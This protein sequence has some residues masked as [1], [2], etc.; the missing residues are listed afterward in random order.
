M[1]IVLIAAPVNEIPALTI[2]AARA[3]K[4]IIVGKP[5]AMTLVEVDRM[6]AAV[7]SAGVTCVPMQGLM[8]L[9]ASG[10]RARIARGDIGELVVLHQTARWSIAEDWYGSGRP[11]WFADPRHVPGGALIDEG[12]YWIDFFRWV[13]G[14]DIVEVEARIANFVHKDIAVEDW[15]QACF[16]LANGVV[17]TLEASWTI[18][19]PRRTGPSPKQNSVVRLEA[20]GTQG[21]LV[22]HWFR[23]PG[24]GV[25][26]AGAPDWVFERQADDAFAPVSP[27]P[28]DHLIDCLE[29]RA[30]PM[31]TLHDAR[32]SLAAALAAY[33]SARERRRV[34]MR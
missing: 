4:H 14:S 33:Q 5:L 7:E 20:I 31:A 3:G 26:A 11:G 1:D 6:A 2:R 10:I 25:L 18:A 32:E 34:T 21:E 13:T 16:T 30:T 19:S 17:A 9:R 27:V 22:D 8:R 15:G 12:I 28:L 29:G 24:L 23:A